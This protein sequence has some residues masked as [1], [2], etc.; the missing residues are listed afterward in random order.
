VVGLDSAIHPS[1]GWDASRTV[2]WRRLT[3]EWLIY[4]AIMAVI[5]GIFFRGQGRLIPILG[6]LLVS[7]PIYL[8]LGYVLAKFGYQ[9]K[10]LAEMRTPRAEPRAASPTGGERPK[11]APTRRTSSGP[12]NRSKSKRR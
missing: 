11:P 9:R 1:V 7:G 2:P 8:A 5:L 4:A 3:K 10:T 12:S 6:G